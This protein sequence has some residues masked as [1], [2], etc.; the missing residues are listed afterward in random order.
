MLALIRGCFRDKGGETFRNF[1]GGLRWR[2]PDRAVRTSSATTAGSLRVGEYRA[3]ESLNAGKPVGLDYELCR[4]L[5]GVISDVVAGAIVPLNLFK[6][7]GPQLTS[8][9]GISPESAGYEIPCSFPVIPCSVVLEASL[10]AKI[11]C[12]HVANWRPG[13]I[14]SGRFPV[15]LPANGKCH[16]ETGSTQTASTAIYMS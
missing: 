15:N 12:K 7:R 3:F 4:L 11:A 8:M 1:F 14:Q 2:P 6:V 10:N 9:H 16:S 13:G 5:F